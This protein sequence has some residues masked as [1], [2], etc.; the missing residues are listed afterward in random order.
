MKITIRN[1]LPMDDDVLAE[2]YNTIRRKEFSW[3]K[4]ETI[5]QD[6][7]QKATREEDIYVAE[8]DGIIAGFLAVYPPDRFIH[9]LF[10]DEKFRHLGAA[11]ALINHAVQIYRDHGWTDEEEGLSQDGPYEL[12]CYKKSN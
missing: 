12:L 2:L 5:Q 3:I 4:A 11:Q 9:H 7:L 8:A 1:A 10:V 6:D